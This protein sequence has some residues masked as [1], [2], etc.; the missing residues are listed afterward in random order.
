M[1][2]RNGSSGALIRVASKQAAL[3]RCLKLRIIPL[4]LAGKV[5]LS[6]ERLSSAGFGSPFLGSCGPGR[7]ITASAKIGMIS[8]SPPQKPLTAYA[9]ILDSASPGPGTPGPVALAGDNRPDGAQDIH[10]LASPIKCHLSMV[11]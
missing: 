8:K 1:R 9:V 5:P 2:L 4:E 10:H 11:R 6:A 7:E 3:K